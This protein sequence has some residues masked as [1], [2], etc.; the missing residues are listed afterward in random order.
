MSSLDYKTEVNK[1]FLAIEQKLDDQDTL[2]VDSLEGLL[3]ITLPSKEQII[4]SQQTQMQEVWLASLSGGAFHFRLTP[5]GWFSS[6]RDELKETLAQLLA[7]QGIKV[8]KHDFDGC[9]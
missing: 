5:Q 2:D 1:L 3:T 8:S 7:Q 9:D 4:L 6:Q